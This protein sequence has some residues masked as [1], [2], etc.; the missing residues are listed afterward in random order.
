MANSAIKSHRLILLQNLGLMNQDYIGLEYKYQNFLAQQGFWR[1]KLIEILQLSFAKE[2]E[3]FGFTGNISI[4]ENTPFQP[5]NL[6]L[7][8]C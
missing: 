2:N 5:D 6:F 1:K 7:H 4:Y 8:V 3:E